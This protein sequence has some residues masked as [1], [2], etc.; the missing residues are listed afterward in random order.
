MPRSWRSEVPVGG[1]VSVPEQIDEAHDHGVKAW[2]DGIGAVVVGVLSVVQA[3]INGQLA[4]QVGSGTEAAVVSFGTGLLM[5][6]IIV[7]LVASGRRGVAR[8]PTRCAA[9][10]GFRSGR[11]SGGLGGA[12]FVASQGLVVPATGVA[13]FTVAVVAGLTANSLVADR[14]GVGP[15][16][17]GRSRC[18]VWWR[19]RS[20]W[21]AS[22]WRSPA[23]WATVTFTCAAHA[24]FRRRRGCG[25]AA[26]RQR[27]GCSDS[28]IA[29]A[30]RPGELRRGFHRAAAHRWRDRGPATARRSSCPRRH[31]TSRCCGSAVR[32]ALPSSWWLRSPCAGSEFWCSPCS[33]SSANSWAGGRGCRRPGARAHRRNGADSG[34]GADVHRSDPAGLLR[35]PPA[36][37]TMTM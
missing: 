2:V 35:Q 24:G 18:R 25:A 6:A 17:G 37:G 21:R 31:G 22:C 4:L 3:R 10:A 28:G 8:S 26:G 20:Q 34:C 32:S 23:S 33:P 5:I 1:T 12:T 29:A 27:Q 30:R 15:G 11:S 36:A 14:F 16:G 9:L 13:L 19:R 7:V